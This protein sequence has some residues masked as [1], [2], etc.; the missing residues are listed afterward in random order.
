VL[1]DL[2]VSPL[3]AR[4]SRRSFTKH[5]NKVR[6][7]RAHQVFTISRETNFLQI[8]LSFGTHFIRANALVPV[9]TRIPSDVQSDAPNQFR[10]EADAAERFQQCLRQ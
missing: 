4:D 3:R 8:L 5:A 9:L 2:L 6:G 10:H 7:G 1:Y